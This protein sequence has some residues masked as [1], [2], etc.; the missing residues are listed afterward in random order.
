VADLARHPDSSAV[1]IGKRIGANGRNA[2][3][4][5]HDAA[6]KGTVPVL[7]A[8]ERPPAMRVAR[9]LHDRQDEV[10]LQEGEFG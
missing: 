8:R 2:D 9:L 6:F 5:L 1:G 4:V 3:R 7:A 10:E